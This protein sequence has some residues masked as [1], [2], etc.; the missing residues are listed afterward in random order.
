[1]NLKEL[2]KQFEEYLKNE[3]EKEGQEKAKKKEVQKIIRHRQKKKK[4]HNP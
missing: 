2:E 4:S 3:F 1:M